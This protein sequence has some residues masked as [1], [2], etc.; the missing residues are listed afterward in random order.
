MFSIEI[1]GTLLNCYVLRL[2]C[3]HRIPKQLEHLATGPVELAPKRKHS[4]TWGSCVPGSGKHPTALQTD[5]WSASALTRKHAVPITV[6]V[7]MEDT[8]GIETLKQEYQKLREDLLR[9]F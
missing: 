5:L 4:S 2:L 3:G 8:G 9:A 1:I 7:G 6:G